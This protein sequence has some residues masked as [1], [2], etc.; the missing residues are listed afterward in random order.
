MGTLK[1]DT[2]RRFR[3]FEG[4][5]I[6]LRSKDYAALNTHYRTLSGRTLDNIMR[7]IRDNGNGIALPRLLDYCVLH[8]RMPEQQARALFERAIA[9]G[10]LSVDAEGIVSFCEGSTVP[11]GFYLDGNGRKSL[12]SP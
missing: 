10:R 4:G 1:A 7:L 3:F 8:Y 9:E 12:L 2:T 5:M 11:S 6:G